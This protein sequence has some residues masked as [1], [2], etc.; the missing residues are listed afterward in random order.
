MNFNFIN[1]ILNL[2]KNKVKKYLEAQ[3]PDDGPVVSPLIF[4]S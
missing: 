3:R 2:K 4:L 1:V